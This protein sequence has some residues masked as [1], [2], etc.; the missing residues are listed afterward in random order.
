MDKLTEISKWDVLNVYNKVKNVVMNYTE[1]EIKVHEATGPEP[2]G[3]S[4]T[5][6]REI[7]DATFDR[8]HC[9]EIMS[10][11][12][13]R[14]NDTNPHNWRQ[15]YKA[16][17]LLEFL[18]KNGSERVV[19]EIRGHITIVKM[20]KNFHHIDANG[21]D[22]GINVRQR[23][24]ELVDLIQNNERLREERKKAKDNRGKYGGF[25]GG[26]RATGFGSTSGGFG[27]SSG[28]NNNN[29]NRGRYD[30]FGSDS[31][32]RSVNGKYSGF[33][34]DKYMSSSARLDDRS[35][36]GSS[37]YYRSE[38]DDRRTPTPATSSNTASG[39]NSSHPKSPSAAK[40]AA[41]AEPVVADLFL[42]DD[43]DNSNGNNTGK[44]STSIVTASLTL[45]APT[46]SHTTTAA[47]T[48]TNTKTNAF[49]N[50]DDWGDFQSGSF[51]TSAPSTSAAQPPKAPNAGNPNGATTATSNAV[52]DLLGGDDMSLGFQPLP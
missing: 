30:G 3:A 20:L 24:K 18:V 42:F 39:R 33:G 35:D 32:G 5:Q 45:P 26:I 2:W 41:P 10:A 1:Y 36:S 6:M 49:G 13:M 9:E 52:M 31:I 8:K 17:Q 23:S 38:T 51:A 40:P 28:N 22:Q 25:A 43:D 19:D 15:V 16:L 47:N 37:G 21:K 12:Y 4:S 44:A 34:S 50:E 46:S 48:K 27:S 11:I 14:F 7:S 29:N